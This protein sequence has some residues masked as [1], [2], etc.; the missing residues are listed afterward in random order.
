M[1]PYIYA[2]MFHSHIICPE[3]GFY[4]RKSSHPTVDAYRARHPFL[5]YY[6]TYGPPG[7]FGSSSVEPTGSYTSLRKSSSFGCQNSPF[8]K[9]HSF[10]KTRKRNRFLGILPLTN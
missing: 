2:H 9:A 7:V 8:D 3:F 10:V 5:T 1:C 4:D 6:S